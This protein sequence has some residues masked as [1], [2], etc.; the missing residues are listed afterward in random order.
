MDS[1]SPL[2]LLYL[3]YKY[4][5]PN[6]KNYNSWSGPKPNPAQI[7]TTLKTIKVFRCLNQYTIDHDPVRSESSSSSRHNALKMKNRCNI[8]VSRSLLLDFFPSLKTWCI[9]LLNRKG[10]NNSSLPCDWLLYFLSYRC[11]HSIL[12]FLKLLPNWIFILCFDLN[13]WFLSPSSTPK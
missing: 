4:W 7:C 11:W 12:C 9:L 1:S 3:H 6:I 8:L 2:T 5:L 10:I 13:Q